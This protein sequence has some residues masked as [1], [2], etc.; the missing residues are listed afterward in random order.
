[1]VVIEDTASQLSTEEEASVY[2]TDLIDS[3]LSGL[4]VKVVRRGGLL[5]RKVLDTLPPVRHV[6]MGRPRG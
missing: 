1:M 6:H 5:A 3:E 4:K 2:I